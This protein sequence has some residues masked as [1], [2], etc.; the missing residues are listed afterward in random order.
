MKAIRANKIYYKAK[1]F[2]RHSEPILPDEIFYE[3]V[4]YNFMVSKE[5]KKLGF[6][7]VQELQMPE[8]GIADIFAYKKDEIIVCECKSEKERNPLKGIGQA[9]TYAIQLYEKG[10]KIKK[11]IIFMRTEPN[12]GRARKDA[13]FLTRFLPFEV[14]LIRFSN[15]TPIIKI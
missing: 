11:A 4:S 1:D 12:K 13:E 6:T 14:K 2:Y 5:L 8:N 3:G 7:V 15:Q 9:L 10:Y